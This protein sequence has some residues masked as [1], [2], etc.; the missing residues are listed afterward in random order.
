MRYLVHHV[1]DAA[2]DAGS[3]APFWK[4]ISFVPLNPV[5]AAQGYATSAALAWSDEGIYA[6]YRCDDRKISCTFKEDGADLFK[7]DVVELFLQPKP[8]LGY[9]FEYELSPL[10]HELALLIA[11][12]GTEFFGWQA[13][14]WDGQR[15]TRRVLRLKKE[16]E[17][18]VGWEAEVFIPFACLSGLTGVPP[19]A[20]DLWRG[21]FYRIDYD[22]PEAPAYLAW[23]P[24]SKPKFHVM[25]EFGEF[26]FQ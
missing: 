11:N 24:V 9:Y 18:L 19:K 20:G 10:G 26:L 12:N 22:N 6:C 23:S 4:G 2:F 15:K 3:A 5:T 13:W 14:K 1:V 8:G 25:D 7:E 17:M 21:N 16:G